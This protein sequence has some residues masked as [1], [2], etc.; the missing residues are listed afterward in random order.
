MS[1][2][3]ATNLRDNLAPQLAILI[4]GKQVPDELSSQIVGFE[5]EFE[6]GKLPVASVTF[7]NQHLIASDHKLLFIGQRIEYSWGFEGDMSPKVSDKITRVEG[8][9]PFTIRTF[10]EESTKKAN[11]GKTSAVHK[12]KITETARKIAQQNN[13]RAEIDPGISIDLPVITQTHETDIEFLRRYANTYGLEFKIVVEDGRQGF[14]LRQ[15]LHNAPPK[16]ELVYFE[17]GDGNPMGDILSFDPKEGSAGQSSGAEHHGVNPAKKQPFAAKATEKD[18]GAKHGK[19]GY[20]VH[21]NAETGKRTIIRGAPSAGHTKPTPHHNQRTAFSA[22]KGSVA[23]NEKKQMEATI[24]SVGHWDVQDGD[25]IKL[26]GLGKRYSGNWT[27][28]K[29]THT[30]NESGYWM[31]IEVYRSAGGGVQSGSAKP[32]R[33]AVNNHS[34]ATKSKG[35]KQLKG[36][37]ISG[38]TGKHTKVFK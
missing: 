1:S 6:T 2:L 37:Y 16:R 12:A 29:V 24:E 5:V 17:D 19:H 21:I 33:A 14:I 35:G 15:P 28:R 27:V 8:F 31:V 22:A 26:T 11:K 18:T 30:I 3:S 34:K 4:G 38:A 25:M 20:Q 23:N 9:K 13:M 7:S 36:V 32:T 10:H